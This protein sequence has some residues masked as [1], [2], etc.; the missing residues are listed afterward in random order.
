[1]IVK[2][3]NTPRNQWLMGRIAETFPSEDGFV[4]KVKLVIADAKLSKT[5]KRTRAMQTL[6]RPIHK[7]V[8]L[9]TCEDQEEFPAK[10]P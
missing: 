4:R 3:D 10:E 6:E 1:M 5:G 9:L 7:L 2:D 8:T